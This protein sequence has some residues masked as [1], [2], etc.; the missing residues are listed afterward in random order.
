MYV[1]RESSPNDVPRSVVQTM[2]FCGF[3]G[4]PSSFDGL[5]GEWCSDCKTA[6]HLEKSEFLY[7]LVPLDI[8]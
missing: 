5:G 7:R 2:L 8:N 4:S 3:C 1:E 6:E